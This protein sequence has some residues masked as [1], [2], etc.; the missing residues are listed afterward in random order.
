MELG[1]RKKAILRAIINDYIQTA[2]PVGSRTISKK[3]EIKISS[4]TIRNE[5]SDLEDLG[6]L[7]QPHTS[8]GRVPSDKAY[9]LY[10][11]EL[12]DVDVLS[13][14]DI[15]YIKSMLQLTAI[16]ELEKVIK[17]T[18]SLISQIT[19]YTSAIL[20]PSVQRS[21]LKSLQL[22]QAS[23]HELLVVVVTDTS[24]IKHVMIKIPKPIT[25][26]T[27]TKI[28]IML[29]D[30][31]R[32]RTIE[33]INLSVISSIQHEMHGYDEILSAIIPVLYESLKTDD[34]D[35]FMEGA[36][37]IFQY[38]EYSDMDSAKKFLTLL[39]QKDV[40]LELFS[41]NQG[42][43]SIS[44]G[45]ENSNDEVKDCSIVKA[46]YMF[47][48]RAIGTI[49]VIGPKRMDYPKVIATLKCCSET[50]NQILKTFND[51]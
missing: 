13:D 25:T 27:L 18:T 38:P 7:E 2:E 4:A 48:D 29:N 11:D 24:L 41:K 45:N 40:M 31:L 1:E 15:S 50:L 16:N 30:K 9:R 42:N 17:K 23:Q 33:E 37:N 49:G 46:S 36:T 44:I 28:N 21:A 19:Q 43:L 8:A 34:S 22:I 32:N 39:E 3:P 35:V 47:G 26:D 10:V 6:Y 14:A 51:E 5:M 12:M 20:S